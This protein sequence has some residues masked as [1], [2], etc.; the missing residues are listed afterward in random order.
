MIWI[1]LIISV[2]LGA[3]AAWIIPTDS[4]TFKYLLAFS[5][6]FLFGTLLTHMIPKSFTRRQK[7]AGGSC[8]VL[9]P[10]NA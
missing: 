6:A 4:K 9:G 7:W 10:I 3:S 8:W 2:G 1:A 5:G